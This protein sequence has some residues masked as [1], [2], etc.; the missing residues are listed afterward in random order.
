MVPHSFRRTREPQQLAHRYLVDCKRVYC[1]FRRVDCRWSIQERPLQVMVLLDVIVLPRSHVLSM[2]A[3]GSPETT[4]VPIGWARELELLRVGRFAEQP[5]D[6][7]ERADTQ[8]RVA[9][10]GRHSPAD[11][12]AD[13]LAAGMQVVGFA[14]LDE[15]AQ[16]WVAAL[17]CCTPTRSIHRIAL[18]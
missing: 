15:P 9:E 13:K 4:L 16:H 5:C 12:P 3:V 10:P 14:N 17:G 18:S 1:L 7:V 11:F 2:V 8:N 6:T